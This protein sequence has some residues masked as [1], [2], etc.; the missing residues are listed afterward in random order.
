VKGFAVNSVAPASRVDCP[1]CR[2]SLLGVSLAARFCPQCGLAVRMILAY[3]DQEIDAAHAGEFLDRSLIVRGYASAMFRLG[4][5]YE[6]GNSGAHN[7]E[8][9]VRCYCKAAR[10]GDENAR[11]RLAPDMEVEVTA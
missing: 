4:W 5:R 10:L 7:P 1:A 8:E 9:A 11:A 2:A 6:M 3:Q